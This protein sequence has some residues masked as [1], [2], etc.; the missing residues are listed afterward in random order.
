MHYCTGPDDG[1]IAGPWLVTTAAGI[2]WNEGICTCGGVLRWAE[3]GYPPWHRIC[4]RCG[5]HWDLHPVA[6]YVSPVVSGTHCPE[7]TIVLHL[8]VACAEDPDCDHYVALVPSTTHPLAWEVA[9]MVHPEH[10]SDAVIAH[11]AIYGGWAQRARF[12]REREPR[13][14]D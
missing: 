13:R 14:N 11:R 1:A 3:A 6:I 8:P 10:L 12:T 2:S 7:D 5:A 4:D 9:R